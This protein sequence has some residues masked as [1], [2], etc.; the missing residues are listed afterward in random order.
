MTS[1]KK[2][3]NPWMQLER[4]L[5]ES[6]SKGSS[7]IGSFATWRQSAPS[8]PLRRVAAWIDGGESFRFE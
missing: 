1:A 8:A 6:I 2:A 5:N 4:L 7:N 3:E